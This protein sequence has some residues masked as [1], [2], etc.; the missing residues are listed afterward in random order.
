MKKSKV[1]PAK[2]RAP[3][4]DP[5]FASLEAEKYAKRQHLCAL[6]ARNKA[7]ESSSGPLTPAQ[8]YWEL[9]KLRD[10]DAAV[11]ETARIARQA[12]A[13]ALG[14]KPNSIEGCVALLR[15]TRR[16][17]SDHPRVASLTKTIANIEKTLIEF[18]S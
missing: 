10:L 7:L 18:N 11:A 2:R 12:Q 14:T 3:Y 9:Y 17:M 13:N 16:L 15:L 8:M 1:D 4:K 6:D 5:V